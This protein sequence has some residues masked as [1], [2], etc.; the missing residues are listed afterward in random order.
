LGHNKGN[1]R[2]AVPL[3]DARQQNV[4][5]NKMAARNQQAAFFR[6]LMINSDN[7]PA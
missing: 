5:A 2:G 7:V 6:Q 3:P 4:P 1:F